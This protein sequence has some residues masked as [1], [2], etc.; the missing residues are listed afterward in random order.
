MVLEYLGN[1]TAIIA[2]DEPA[3]GRQHFCGAPFL[4]LATP[5]ATILN[6]NVG[7]STYATTGQGP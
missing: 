3:S 1:H 6:E 5:K 4:R 2:P 7:I